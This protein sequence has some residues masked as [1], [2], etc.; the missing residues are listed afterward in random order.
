MTRASIHQSKCQKTGKQV[1]VFLKIRAPGKRVIIHLIYLFNL[2][3]D[4]DNGEKY[5]T[6]KFV[7][8]RRGNINS[9]VP[10]HNIV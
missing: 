6:D 1:I 9:L 2:T 5:D 4:T 10:L 8:L 3:Q 7:M